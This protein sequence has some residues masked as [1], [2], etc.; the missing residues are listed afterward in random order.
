MCKLENSWDKFNYRERVFF[1]KSTQETCLKNETLIFEGNMVWIVERDIC[2]TSLFVKA[3]LGTCRAF[4]DTKTIDSLARNDLAS[5]DSMIDLWT[6]AHWG[7]IA[8]ENRKQCSG[9]STWTRFL[10]RKGEESGIPGQ[11]V[12]WWWWLWWQVTFS[13]LQRRERKS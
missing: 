8:R 3:W 10:I 9:R 7:S 5:E 13:L 12:W 6:L 2:L 4:E 1:V 11:M